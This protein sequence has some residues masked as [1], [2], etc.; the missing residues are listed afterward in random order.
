LHRQVLMPSEG[1][2][3]EDVT[4][5]LLRPM[6]KAWLDEHLAGMVQSAVEA[7]VERISRQRR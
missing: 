7:E 5:E 2:S 3:L 4:R 1:R 6:L